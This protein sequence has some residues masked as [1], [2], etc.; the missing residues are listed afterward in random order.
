[1]NYADICHCIKTAFHCA[2]DDSLKT[3]QSVIDSNVMYLVR[4]DLLTGYTFLSDI[5]IKQRRQNLI[6]VLNNVRS[7]A[8]NHFYIYAQN[9]F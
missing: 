5:D 9:D 1:M 8:I 3:S 2:F 7:A 6:G 4:N